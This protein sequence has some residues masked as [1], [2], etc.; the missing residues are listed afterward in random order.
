M[1]QAAGFRLI[2]K[3]ML[4][5]VSNYPWNDRIQEYD[6]T[7]SLYEKPVPYAISSDLSL[8]SWRKS[9]P[10]ALS[11]NL[12]DYTDD[13]DDSGEYNGY[14]RF[15]WQDFHLQY[16]QGI[17]F[18]N[19]S[20]CEYLTDTGFR[21]LTGVRE[22]LMDHTFGLTNQAFLEIAGVEKLSICGANIPKITN[23]AFKYL[24]SKLKY[25]RMDFCNLPNITP[26]I[27]KYLTNLEY[28]SIYACRQLEYADLRFLVER[29]CKVRGN[30]FNPP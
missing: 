18:V 20:S 15:Q 14:E 4:E 25:L 23:N 22:L 5:N 21:F 19:I 29:G 3:G 8:A 13:T 10:W 27:F 12:S 30:Y 7:W 2:N 28:L 1:A 17:P 6:P 26:D 11:V 16:L 24:G 9:F